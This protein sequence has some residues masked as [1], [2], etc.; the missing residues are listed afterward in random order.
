MATIS[1]KNAANHLR[2]YQEKVKQMKEAG[3]YIAPPKLNPIE[4]AKLDPKSMRKAITAMCFDCIGGDH[5]P[6]FRGRIKDCPC[7]DCPLYYHR[8]YSKKAAD[9][10][11]ED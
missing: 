2:E 3:T 9:F 4:R 1:N 7:T 6:D 10:K 5:D 11:K 8:P